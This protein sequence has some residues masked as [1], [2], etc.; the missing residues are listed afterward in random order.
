[1]E[2]GCD[3]NNGK[4]VIQLTTRHKLEN[5]QN[6]SIKNLHNREYVAQSESDEMDWRAKSNPSQHF[7]F[8]S[9]M[10]RT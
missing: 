3:R 10:H 4:V 7:F 6:W 9:D 1:M 2:A 5:P 8:A